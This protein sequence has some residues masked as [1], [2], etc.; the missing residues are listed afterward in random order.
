M[1]HESVRY[2]TVRNDLK[3]HVVSQVV[4]VETRTQSITTKVN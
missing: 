2:V 4:P 3:G 1:N